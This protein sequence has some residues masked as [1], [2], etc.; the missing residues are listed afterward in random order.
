MVAIILVGIAICSLM[1]GILLGRSAG[2][3]ETEVRLEDAY[4]RGRDEGAVEKHN[5][6]MELGDQLSKMRN[7][8]QQTVEAYEQTVS[9]VQEKLA[10]EPETA[11][12]LFGERLAIVRAVPTELT[13]SMMA[14][15]EVPYEPR[16]LLAEGSSFP[17]DGD[18]PELRHAGESRLLVERATA[19]VGET[20]V[21]GAA[22]PGTSGQA[23]GGNDG[24]YSN[25][26]VSDRRTILQ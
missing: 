16:K 18:V 12:R 25:G 20:E 5:L 10:L 6:A 4:R 26:E 11:D 21:A 7:S 13:G 15:N 8:I 24:A 1:V 23:A 22:T 14:R 17:P 9:V 2:E 19:V 3:S